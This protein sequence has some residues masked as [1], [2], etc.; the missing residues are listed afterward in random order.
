MNQTILKEEVIKLV[1]QINIH[2]LK[3]SGDVQTLNFEG[4]VNFMLQYAHLQWQTET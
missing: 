1:K 4:F 2:I 3:Q